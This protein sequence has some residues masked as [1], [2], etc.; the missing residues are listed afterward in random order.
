VCPQAQQNYVPPQLKKTGPAG[1]K[2]LGDFFKG[3]MNSGDRVDETKDGGAT[4]EDLT[5]GK[6]GVPFQA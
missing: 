5:A 6:V 2:D 4:I 1:S 3:L